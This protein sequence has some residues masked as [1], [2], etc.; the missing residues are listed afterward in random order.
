MPLPDR[1][2]AII[3][4][5]KAIPS[6]HK[7]WINMPVSVEGFELFCYHGWGVVPN[8]AQL[9]GFNDI[10]TWPRGTFHLWRWANRTGKTSGLILDHEYICF[11]KWAYEQ[12]DLDAWLGYRYK[13]LHAAPEG[14]LMRKAWEIADSLL[15]GSSILQRNPMTNRQRPGI[16]VGTPMFKATT[17]RDATGQEQLVVLVANNAKVDFLQTFAGAGRMESD[18]WWFIDWDEFGEHKPIGNVPYLV[19]ST[20]LPRSA[21]FMAPVVLSS[22]EKETN[23]AVYM[24]LEDL[25]DRSPADWNIK[26]FG[27]EVNFAMSRAS[28]DRQLRMSSD[29]ATAQRSVYGGSAESSKGSVLPLFTVARA[30]DPERPIGRTLDDLPEPQRGKRWKIIQTFDHAIQGDRNVVLTSAVQWPIT[31]REEL[32]AHPIEGLAI[33]ERKGSRVL[34]PDEVSRWALRQWQE[35]GEPIEGSV[36]VTDTTGEGGIMFHR[37]LRAAG[38]PSREFNYTARVGKNDRR[39]KKGH[40]RTGLQRLFSL[41]LPV[42]EE[43]GEIIVPHGV[44]IEELQFGGIR[45]PLPGPDTEEGRAF[46][47][48]WRQLAILKVDDEKMAQD[49]AMTALMLAGFIYPYIERPMRQK[50]I[51]ANIMGR[52]GDRYRGL[53]SLR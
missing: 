53:A 21:D 28:I 16:F 19:D 17:Q 13:T 49:H 26:E 50:P 6:K 35:Y 43:T 34:T 42:D 24:E 20:F 9:E 10:I 31:D 8:D 15:D 36:W 30:F 38:I 27:R 11:K 2:R 48:L 3:D 1:R 4:A 18:A 33:A 7:A 52:R 25:R 47:K 22:T 39:T 46:R 23:V 41:G 12:E 45:F 5:L 40:G 14:T 51:P 29:V 32:I 37:I 44:D